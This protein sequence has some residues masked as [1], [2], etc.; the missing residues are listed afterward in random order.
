MQDRG[1][2]HPWRQFTRPGDATAAGEVCA[3]RKTCERS[4]SATTNPRNRP[5]GSD[6]T[7]TSPSFGSSSGAAG[8][9]PSVTSSEATAP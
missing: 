5:A 3:R 4:R 9:A 7:A 1:D 6:A 2:V 8:G